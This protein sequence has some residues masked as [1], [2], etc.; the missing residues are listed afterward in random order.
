[1]LVIRSTV[2]GAILLAVTN[3][4]VVST[5]LILLFLYMIG[6]QLMTLVIE[7]ERAQQFKLYQ[8]TQI[9]KEQAVY[10]LI[11]QLLVFVAICLALASVNQLGITGL[12]LVPI[13]CLFAY[14]FSK[15]YAPSRV[16]LLY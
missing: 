1:M 6:F 8:V 10:K 9:E 15:F 14:L 4:L 3:S 13:G 11:F 12:V 7:I 16:K 2:V 5:L